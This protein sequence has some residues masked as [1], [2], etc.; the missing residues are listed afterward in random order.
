MDGRHKTPPNALDLAGKRFGKLVAVERSGK[1]KNDSALWLCQCDCG[2]TAIANA[3]SLRIGDT[4]SCG[5]IKKE[6]IDHARQVL[7][8]EMTVDGV[9]VPLLTKKTRSDSRT[10]HKGVSKR[11]RK[12]LTRYEV[13][14]TVKGKR[15][16]LG[17]YKNIEDAIAA[18][19]AAE[20]QYFDPYIK[21]LQD[22]KKKTS[23]D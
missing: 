17:G 6:Q 21:A 23:L 15:I 4:I 19:K 5:C 8:D 1:T 16:Y 9:M 20:A 22:K 2:N 14:I 7:V 13:T 11:V 10:G 12:G 3:T 18:R